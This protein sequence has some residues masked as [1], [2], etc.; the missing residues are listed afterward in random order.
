MIALQEAIERKVEYLGLSNRVIFAGIRSG[1]GKKITTMNIFVFPS[2]YEGLPVTLV[3]TQ[4]S[5]LP[6]VDN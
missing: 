4:A 2:L 3:E 1:C 6:C 5:G